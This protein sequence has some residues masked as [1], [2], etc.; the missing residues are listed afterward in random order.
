MLW[1]FGVTGVRTGNSTKDH[2]RRSFIK[3]LDP[4]FVL[5]FIAM[6]VFAVVKFSWLW[7]FMKPVR[8]LWPIK[9]LRFVCS[10]FLVCERCTEMTLG[11]SHLSNVLQPHEPRSASK[12]IKQRRQLHPH[13]LTSSLQLIMGNTWAPSRYLETVESWFDLIMSPIM[14]V[15]SWYIC[16][17]TKEM[18]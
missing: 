18:H 17:V 14:E 6:S 1:A 3:L 9:D 7:L 11:L 16:Q 5:K 8:T 4:Y 13:L 10:S 2:H 15:N 12:K